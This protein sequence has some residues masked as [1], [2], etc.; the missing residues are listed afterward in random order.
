MNIVIDVNL[1]ISFLI[2]KRLSILQSLLTNSNLTIFVCNELLEELKKVSSKQKIR[3][4]VSKNDIE[5]LFKIIGNFC[6]HVAIQQEAISPV[7]D[8]KDL[9]LLSLA[10]TVKANYIITGDKDLLILQTHNQTKIVTY[11]DFIMKNSLS[12]HKK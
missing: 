1:W 9:Y 12:E 6:E 5:D 3:K 7:R 10:D 11:N 4:Y 8:L 2:G